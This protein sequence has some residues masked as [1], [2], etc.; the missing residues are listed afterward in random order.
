MN[1]SAIRFLCSNL[2]KD[3][4]ITTA[5]TFWLA[6]SWLALKHGF[7]GCGH[8]FGGCNGFCRL[9]GF[10]RFDRLGGFDGFRGLDGFSG[11]DRLVF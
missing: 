5:L 8:G 6:F 2:I 7:S 9:G 3:E 4:I 10:G 11:F 1:K